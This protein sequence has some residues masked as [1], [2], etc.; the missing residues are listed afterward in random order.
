MKRKFSEKKGLQ[1]IGLLLAIFII[2]IL[3]SF[4]HFRYD[5]TEDKRYSLTKTTRQLL[6]EVEYPLLVTVFL[7]GDYPSGFKKLSNTTGDFLR[8][9]RETNSSK[10][11]YRFVSPEDEVDGKSWADS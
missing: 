9:L 1:W 3:A 8:I 4:I 11:Q 6:K 7:K 5:L 2:N 10:I